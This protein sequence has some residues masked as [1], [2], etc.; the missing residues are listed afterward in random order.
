MIIDI[1]KDSLSINSKYLQFNISLISKEYKN[2]EH[3]IKQVS[4]NDMI[5]KY[6]NN[7]TSFEHLDYITSCC[8]GPIMFNSTIFTIENNYLM[9]YKYDNYN[10]SE[11]AKYLYQNNYTEEELFIKYGDEAK[12]IIEYEGNYEPFEW[13]LDIDEVCKVL[14]KIKE[15]LIKYVI[16]LHKIKKAL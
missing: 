2:S 14:L 1:N 9:I 12:Y 13:S 15:P 4:I 10:I 5:K 11:V 3:V 8:N 16:P 7:E 6:E